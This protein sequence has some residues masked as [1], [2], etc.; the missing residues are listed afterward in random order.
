[1]LFPRILTAIVGVP[2]ILLALATG[3]LPLTILILGIS[4][5]CLYEIFALFNKMGFPPRT[6]FGYPLAL[7][8]FGLFILPSQ[9]QPAYAAI[10]KSPSLLGLGL[11]LA[12][13]LLTG[14]ELFYIHTRSLVSSAVTL[15]AI[16]FVTWPLAHVVLIRDLAPSGQEWSFF[17][18]VT[19]W[20]ADIFAYAIGMKWGRKQ[21]AP[22]VSPK[23]TVEGL[24]G[25]LLGAFCASGAFWVM[26]FRKEGFEF[27]EIALLGVLGLGIGGQISDLVESVLKRQARVKDSSAVLPGHGGFLDRF[28]SFF[29]TA[30]LLYYYLA[31]RL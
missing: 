27:S 31:F 19:I 2:V 23:K 6:L 7:V 28:D 20:V 17:L 14:A 18:F 26:V 11:T 5:L 8:L 24:A 3:G 12:V 16:L 10:L 21:L 1:M 22:A 30:P 15:F 29:L 9:A 25:T 4:L 13:V